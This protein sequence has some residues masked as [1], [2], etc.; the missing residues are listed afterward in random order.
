VGYGLGDDAAAVTEML[1]S[2]RY[3]TVHTL[4]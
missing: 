4:N 3:Q 2:G 1:R